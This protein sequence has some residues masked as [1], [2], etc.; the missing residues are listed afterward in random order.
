MIDVERAR[1][2]TPGVRNRLHFNNAGAALMPAPV[3]RAMTDHLAR[4][5]EV[6]GYEAADEAEDRL[7]GVYRSLARLLNCAPDEVAVVENATRAWDMAFYAFDFRPGDR[8][9][10]AAAEYASNYIAYLQL[11]RKTG[12][13]VEAVPDDDSGQLDV[14]ALERMIDERVRL[15]SVT[16]VPTNGGL[17]NPARAIGKVARPRGVPFLLDACQ[18][19]GQM[20]LDVEDL[21]VDILSAAGRK[22]LRGPRGVGFLY[23]RRSLV[24]R[25]E[26]PLL[27]LH[28]ATWTAAAEYEVRPD[29][30]RF[31]NWECNVSAK[32]GLGAAVDYALAWGLD[33]IRDRVCGLADELRR[34]LASVPGV[35][36]HDRGAVKCGI[37]S[38]TCGGR[39]AAAVRDALKG[40]GMN[41]IVS[42]AAYTRIDMDR[43]GLAEVVR[44]S[45][46][47]YNT[48]EEV[49]RFTAA[50]ADIASG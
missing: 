19:A 49:E 46:H 15:I 24:E 34:R 23:V 26:P 32:L 38:F 31:E 48:A 10:T 40:R 22:Y 17:V 30:R 2:E 25:L 28:A 4:E 1:A 7:E 43:R 18:S 50:V 36:V 29:A 5:A 42:P 11:A 14:D 37:V 41:V 6:G 33:A 35:A 12:V 8:V 21:G 20:P 27:D 44:A 3:L 9:L 47:Y 45:V 13:R 16:H 39:T